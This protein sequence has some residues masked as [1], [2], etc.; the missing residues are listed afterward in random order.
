M[1]DTDSDITRELLLSAL[2]NFPSFV[3]VDCAGKI[4]YMNENYTKILGVTQ[5]EAIGNFVE[6]VIPNT[7]R[8]IVVK[9]GKEEI[10]ALMRFFDHGDGK[11]IT[12]VCSRIPIKKNGKIIG[13]IGNT[14]IKDINAVSNIHEEINA[15]KLQNKQYKAKID[16]LESTL[17]P[18]ENLVGTSA[19]FAEAKKIILDY[20]DTNLS[21]LI[22]GETGTGKE[23]VAKVIH[24]LSR[25]VLNNFVKINCAAIPAEL[26]E[27]ELFGYVEG[28]FTGAKQGG[29]I[30]KYEL[31][32]NGTLLL[33][34]IAEMRF[35][36]Q[37]KLL[38]VL[39]EGEF[40]P[41][42]GVQTRKANI[43]LICSTNKNLVKLVEEGRFREDLYYR[44]NVVE[45]KLPPLRERIADI[46]FS[47][48]AE[49]PEIIL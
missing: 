21:I 24:H 29:K 14:I 39:Q 34:E 46:L 22:T 19:R 28:A 43:R 37:A 36:L 18:F 32:H 8:P 15:L 33:D 35:D 23:P 26:L 44:I 10:G 27:S 31:A 40:E 20:A 25:R 48:F 30:G 7:R 13:A 42:G 16:V 41:V 3:I 2:E 47:A 5:K 9:T 12:L 45:I 49:R 1:V 6:N 11:D 4:V 38:R 17:N